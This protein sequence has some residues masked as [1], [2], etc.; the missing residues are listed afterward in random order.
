MDHI[1]I[2]LIETLGSTLKLLKGDA[3]DELQSMLHGHNKNQLPDKRIAGLAKTAVNLLHETEQLLEPGSLVLADHFLGYLSTK[4]LCAAVELNVPDILRNGPRTVVELAEEANAHPRRLRQVLRMLHNDGIFTYDA[5]TDQ[6]KNNPTSEMLLSDHWTQWHNWVDLYGNEFYD[7]ARGIPASC[8]KDVTRMAGQIQFDTDKDLFTYFTEQGWLS[9]LHRTLSGGAAAQAP[10]ILVDYPWEEIAEECFLDVGGGGGGLVALLLR[11]HK[12]M[13]AGILDTAKVIEHATENFHGPNGEYADVGDRVMPSML[14]VGDFLFKIP[15]F[16]VYTMKWCLHDW[17]DS[18][19]LKVLENI[20]K[21]IVRGPKSR[22]IIFESLLTD[23]RMGRLARYGDL[24]MAISANGEERDESQWRS[25]ARQTRWDVRNI[26]HLRDAWP[27]AIE[28]V[29][30]WESEATDVTV[31]QTPPG[32]PLVSEAEDQNTA[33]SSHLVDEFMSLSESKVKDEPLKLTNGAQKSE[34]Q[35]STTMSFLEPWDS[36]QG[37]PYYRSMPDEGFQSQNFKWAEHSVTVINA[38]GR[39][40]DFSL[41]KNGFCY[42]NDPG[43]M[44][45]ELVEALREGVKEVVRDLYYPE[46]ERLVKRLTGASRV[47]IFDHTVRK[48]DPVM[49]KGENPNGKEQP[50]TVVHC[51]QSGKGALRRV[52]QNIGDT[53]SIDTLLKG[54]IRMINVWRPL[55]GPVLDWPLA[56]MDFQTLSPFDVHNCDLWRHQFE[57]RGQTVTYTRNEAQKWYYLDK[58]EIDEVTMIKIWD[59]MDGHTA[60][61]KSFQ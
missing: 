22:L 18:K 9:R 36:S 7:M 1:L 8:R 25:L 59:S 53:E 54:R 4:C 23:G 61:S 29:P 47:I 30:I 15:S 51:D 46:V 3:K 10:G 20:R 13:R 2:H 27:C 45:P 11:E 5:V 57:E 55:R 17:D 37:E 44:T 58:H 28:L 56:T 26:Y 52:K 16:E 14:I 12:S 60:N 39:I 50:A 40:N 19:A 43:T 38:R 21:A 49:K 24:T 35:V 48:R 31:L 42:A 6:Y 33:K 34:S 32:T 41:D